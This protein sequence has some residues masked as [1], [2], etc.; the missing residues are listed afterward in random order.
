MRLND[1]V[2]LIDKDLGYD[3]VL[4]HVSPVAR[5]ESFYTLSSY[6]FAPDKNL[7]WDALWMYGVDSK[8]G[9]V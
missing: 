4:E 9:G 2:S 5:M 8:F 7:Q 3:L 6:A 1:P